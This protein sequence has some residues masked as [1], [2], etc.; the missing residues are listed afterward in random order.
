MSLL[1]DLGGEF[2]GCDGDSDLFLETIALLGPVESLPTDAKC[3]V[4]VRPRSRLWVLASTKATSAAIVEPGS[5]GIIMRMLLDECANRILS[6]LRKRSSASSAATL[7]TGTHDGFHITKNSFSPVYIEVRSARMSKTSNSTVEHGLQPRLDESGW[8]MQKRWQLTL[9]YR[10]HNV[11]FEINI[12]LLTALRCE[13][14]TAVDTYD[15]AAVAALAVLSIWIQ[16]EFVIIIGVVS[17]VGSS[18]SAC[19]VVNV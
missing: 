10:F 13:R 12:I 9:M 19:V 4:M 7:L 5:A 15:V 8:D 11:V 17:A 14:Q 3:D 18:I 2:S 1:W 6:A 16:S